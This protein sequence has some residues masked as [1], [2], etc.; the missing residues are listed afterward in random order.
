MTVEER[1]LRILREEFIDRRIESKNGWGKN[2]IKKEF[3]QAVVDSLFRV[4]GERGN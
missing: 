4:L 1:V 2:E 3:D